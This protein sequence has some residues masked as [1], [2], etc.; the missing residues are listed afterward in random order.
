MLMSRNRDGVAVDLTGPADSQVVEAIPVVQQTSAARESPSSAAPA[1]RVLPVHF[2]QPPADPVMRILSVGFRQPPA[3]LAG[4]L[5]PDSVARPCAELTDHT[6]PSP[7][8]DPML[9]DPQHSLGDPDQSPPSDP[10]SVP[11]EATQD[12]GPEMPAPERPAMSGQRSGSRAIRRWPPAPAQAAAILALFLASGVIFALSGHHVGSR[13]SIGGAASASGATVT[14][15]D[16]SAAAA[17]QMAAKWVSQQVSHG[18]TV[19]CDPVTCSALEARGVTS[20]NLLILRATAASPLGANMVVATPAVRSQFGSRLDSVYAPSVIAGFGSGPGRVTVQVIA[21]DGAAAYLAELRQDVAAR[22]AAGAQLLANKRIG[23]TALVGAQLAAGEVD[24]RLLIMFAA[25]AAKHPIQILA[26][27]D[28]G[29]DAS[30]GVPLCSADLS[31]S[32]Q[33][34]GISDAIYLR[35]LAGFLR[36]QL[37]P[38]AGSFVVLQQGDQPVVR[39]ELSRPSPLGLLARA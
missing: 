9:A 7:P 25:L 23:T 35:W 8:Q 5:L 30:P 3:D 26:F 13:P 4:R 19:A 34:A 39:V 36:V 16:R 33:A 29:P 22:K 10:V 38:F 28:P 11:P 18:A 17:I 12:P 24:S 2:R 27:G 6:P 21:P 14:S 1:A 37:A 32:G 20:A 31:G 15:L